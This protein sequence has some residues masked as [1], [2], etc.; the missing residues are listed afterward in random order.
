MRINTCIKSG[1]EMEGDKKRKC[2]RG[3]KNYAEEVRNNKVN[4]L[5]SYEICRYTLMDSSDSL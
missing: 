3:K 4:K 5:L 2:A 1:W